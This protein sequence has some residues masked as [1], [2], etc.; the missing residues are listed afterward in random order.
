[1]LQYGK[2]QPFFVHGCLEL[3]QSYLQTHQIDNAKRVFL[4]ICSSQPSSSSWLGAGIAFYEEND[5]IRAE[6]ALV[7]GNVLDPWNFK[8]WVYLALVC[9]R[10]QRMEAAEFASNQALQLH[11]SPP[12]L[13]KLAECFYEKG[14]IRAAERAVIKAC[15][16]G[17]PYAVELDSLCGKLG[18]IKRNDREMQNSATSDVTDPNVLLESFFDTQPIFPSP[19]SSPL[20]IQHPQQQDVNCSP[21]VPT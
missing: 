4:E 20:T 9:L 13:I 15:E 2:E 5:M 14:N 6:A 10:T 8:L 21:C 3:G 1:M 19:L 17:T 18:L 16:G 7:E 11:P 12:L